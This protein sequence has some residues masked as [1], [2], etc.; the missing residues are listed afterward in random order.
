[1]RKLAS[2]SL[3]LLGAFGLPAAATPV[4]FSGSITNFSGPPAPGGR[5]APALTLSAGPAGTSGHSSLGDFIFTL[6]QC[7]AAPPPTD[8]FNGLFDFDFANG[9]HLYGT[10]SGTLSATMNPNVFANTSF[11]V[12][13]GG[14]GLFADASGAFSGT[15][16]VTRT[17]GAPTVAA[18]SF[19]GTLDGVPEPLTLALFG[20]AVLG[21]FAAKRR[22]TR[23]QV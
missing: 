14:T 17:P 20:T 6:S 12:V 23:I 11:Y 16:T 13:T 18:L 22:L 5:C 7:I 2:L 1:M 15:G 8:Y 19:S 3:F 4:A 21:V 9:N 10:N